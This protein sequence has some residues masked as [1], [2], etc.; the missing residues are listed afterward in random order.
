MK[1]HESN[2]DG[3]FQFFVWVSQVKV[4]VYQS[5]CVCKKN[6][7]TVLLYETEQSK[8]KKTNLKNLN[9]RIFKDTHREE[10]PSNKSL[11]KCMNMDIWVVDT[12]NQF[13]T[14]GS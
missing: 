3:N 11:T 6:E 1:E 7:V 10:T 4:L 13:F 12:S 8:K 5:C 9:V 14:R 2:Q